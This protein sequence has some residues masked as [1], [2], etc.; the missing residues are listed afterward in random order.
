MITDG[1]GE[2]LALVYP[3]QQGRRKLGKSHPAASLWKPEI[4]KILILKSKCHRVGEDPEAL[5]INRGIRERGG[6]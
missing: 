5:K 1:R 4:E 3:L 2:R 6:G